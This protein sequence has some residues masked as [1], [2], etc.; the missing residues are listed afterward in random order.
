MEN[1]ETK[2]K[3]DIESWNGNFDDIKLNSDDSVVKMD[4]PVFLIFAEFLGYVSKFNKIANEW[5]EGKFPEEYIQK[6]MNAEARC[7]LHQMKKDYTVQTMRYWFN[8]YHPV[9]L[10][11]IEEKLAKALTV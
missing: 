8:T 11:E 6:I 1:T 2:T 10:K 9:V 7:I 4:T 5:V 3:S